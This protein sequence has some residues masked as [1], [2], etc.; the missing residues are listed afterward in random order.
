MADDVD[1]ERYEALLDGFVDVVKKVG[2][3]PADIMAALTHLTGSTIHALAKHGIW[4]KE[5]LI[6]KFNQQL[7]ETIELLEGES[8]DG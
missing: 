8:D 3:E 6:K 4:K 5:T 7:A 1:L 2:F